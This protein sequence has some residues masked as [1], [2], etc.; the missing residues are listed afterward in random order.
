MVPAPPCRS[1]SGSPADRR[2]LE[3]LRRKE[4]RGEAASL[5][6]AKCLLLDAFHS[7]RRCAGQRTLGALR[8]PR[9]A[10]PC[11]QAAASSGPRPRPCQLVGQRL[12][13]PCHLLPG[14]RLMEEGGLPK[15]TRVE[16]GDPEARRAVSPPCPTLAYSAPW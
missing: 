16:F 10:A 8:V 15:Q 11:R 13:P 1:K 7:A 12:W 6:E 9:P 5:L 2:Q 14:C 4:L 3:Q